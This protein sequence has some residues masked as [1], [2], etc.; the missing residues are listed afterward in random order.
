MK[1][2]P[3]FPKDNPAILAVR[4]DN[5]RL[6]EWS[7]LFDLWSDV[8]YLEYFFEENKADLCGGYFGCPTVDEAVN[9]IL[10]DAWML[11]ERLLRLADDG[12]LDPYNTLQT[13]FSPLNNEIR[14]AELQKSKA[15]IYPFRKSSWLRLYAIRIAPNLYVV[16]GGA[17][18]LTH[19]ME[20]REHTRNELVKLEK[21]KVYLKNQGLLHESDFQFLEI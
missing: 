12:R 3:I 5:E 11:E 17:I 2:V 21:V 15:R 13:I 10:D 8:E 18:K 14:L 1:I 9:R 6:D 20:E 16:T 4:Y 7:R 19:R